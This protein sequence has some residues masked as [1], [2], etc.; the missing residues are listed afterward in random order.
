VASSET[1]RAAQ[2]S[3]LDRLVDPD[4]RASVDA[5]TSLAESV[6]RAKTG[7][8]RD[9]EWLLN[10]RRTAIKV[11]DAL[12]ELRSSV[13][14]FG[15]PDLSSLSHDAPGDRQRL[16]RSVEATIAAFEPRMAD[17]RVSLVE[18]ETPAHRRELHFVIEGTFLLDPTPLRVSYDTVMDLSKGECVL[19]GDRA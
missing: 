16:L 5:P 7:L 4:P 9:I 10:T 12:E 18:E 8:R 1:E 19:R 11:P 13:F 3:L 2:P 14:F 15:L 6:R 17:V